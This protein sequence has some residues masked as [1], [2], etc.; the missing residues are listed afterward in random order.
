VKTLRHSLEW[1]PLDLAAEQLGYHPESL[2]KRL[3]QLRQR[4]QVVDLGRPPAG[5][6]VGKTPVEGKVVL[7]WANPKTALIRRNAPSDLLVPK[8]GKRPRQST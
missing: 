3:R 2:R 6:T 7:L 5:Y 4:G 8:R 1:Q